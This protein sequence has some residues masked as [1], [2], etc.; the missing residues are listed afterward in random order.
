MR[1]NIFPTVAVLTWLPVAETKNV[2]RE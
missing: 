1:P 2:R